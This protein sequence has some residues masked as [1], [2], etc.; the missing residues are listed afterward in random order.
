M[1]L[2]DILELESELCC[3]ELEKFDENLWD[4]ARKSKKFWEK[5]FLKV[6]LCAHLKK[7]H[8]AKLFDIN[9][10][11]KTNYGQELQIIPL[12]DSALG[13]KRT[14]LKKESFKT[15]L[16]KPCNIIAD[17]N[18]SDII[19]NKNSIFTRTELGG[20]LLNIDFLNGEYGGFTN[21][22]CQ[23]NAGPNFL[24]L[25]LEHWSAYSANLH[26]FGQ[27]KIWNIVSPSNY[28]QTISLLKEEEEKFKHLLDADDDLYGICKGTLTHRM[29]FYY[30]NETCVRYSE[31]RQIPGD[32]IFVAPFG[33]HEVKNLGE[34][35]A[36][37]INYLPVDSMELPASYRTCNHSEAVNGKPELFPMT[38]RIKSELKNRRLTMENCIHFSDLHKKEKLCAFYTWKFGGYQGLADDASR[39]IMSEAEM[40]HW[41][42]LH[43]EEKYQQARKRA[44]NE[45]SPIGHDYQKYQSLPC[46]ENKCNYETSHPEDFAKHMKK[47]H[48]KDISTSELPLF[49]CPHCFEEVKNLRSHMNRNIC[50][51]VKNDKDKLYKCEFCKSI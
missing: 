25:H 2:T 34:N 19:R 29:L 51:T 21:S 27:P 26:H 18:F 3:Q 17:I 23:W 44:V 7:N 6:H 35:F 47:I 33:L 11:Q 46:K 39:I 50:F 20:S 24:G 48:R 45:R 49:E 14:D 9:I 42:D 1:T 43:K 32:L 13:L 16:S 10:N 41:F 31:V 12:S 22:T 28:Y 30:M 15:I 40:P 38:K 37:S 5:G 4:A 8:V 36:E